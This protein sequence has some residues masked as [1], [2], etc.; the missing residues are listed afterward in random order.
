MVTLLSGG[1][2]F[3]AT[4]PEVKMQN[5]NETIDRAHPKSILPSTVFLYF[6]RAFSL[7]GPPLQGAEKKSGVPYILMSTIGIAKRPLKNMTRKHATWLPTRRNLRI[8]LF[9]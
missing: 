2:T 1:G 6:L 8:P 4:Q 3:V 5:V 9:N 7:I